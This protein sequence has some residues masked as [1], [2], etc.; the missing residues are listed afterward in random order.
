LTVQNIIGIE[1]VG[2]LPQIS[3]NEVV[4]KLKLEFH[5]KNCIR[6]NNKAYTDAMKPFDD[7]IIFL[8]TL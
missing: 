7:A 6:C 3:L 2:P 4:E 5:I 1:K 8:T